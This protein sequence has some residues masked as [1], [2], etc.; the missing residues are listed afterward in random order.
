MTFK[1][2]LT[3]TARKA[4]D[5]L[6]PNA[7]KRIWRHIGELQKDPFRPRPMAN[8]VPVEGSETLYRLRIGKFRVEYEV[9]KNDNT[10]IILRIFQK[11]RKSDYR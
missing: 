2:E 6:Q 8:I 3:R 7:L 5:K 11:K 1:I 10:I 9:N 4:L